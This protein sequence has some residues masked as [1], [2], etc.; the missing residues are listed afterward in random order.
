MRRLAVG[1]ARSACGAERALGETAAMHAHGA[2]D[3]SHDHAHDHTGTPTNRL[4]VALVVSLIV[5][6]VEIVGGLA[7]NSLALLSD[8][9]HVFTDVFALGLAWFASRQAERPPNTR[10]TYGFHRAGILA[11]LA[12]AAI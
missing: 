5:L 10:Q 4:L 2:H 11:A 7:S 12:N 1:T 8:A 3:H 9:V 6:A